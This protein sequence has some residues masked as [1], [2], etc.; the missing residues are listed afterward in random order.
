MRAVAVHDESLPR[1]TSFDGGI[2]HECHEPIGTEAD[3]S[4][5]ID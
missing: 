4:W 5:T 2:M 1:C 3:A